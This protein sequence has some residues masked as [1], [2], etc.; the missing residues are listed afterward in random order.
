MKKRELSKKKVM[1]PTWPGIDLIT[2][3][4]VIDPF[5]AVNLFKYSSTVNAPAGLGLIL[6]N[7]IRTAQIGSCIGVFVGLTQSIKIHNVGVYASR[8]GCIGGILGIS[9]IFGKTIIDQSMS[10][11]GIDEKTSQLKENVD[12]E[13]MT[14]TTLTFS[15]Y[16]NDV[17]G[18]LI[19][20]YINYSNIF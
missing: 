11:L 3:N 15:M 5:R 19:F 18:S 20:F 13:T 17:V 12:D 8:G 7:S 16:V 4:G 10:P 6:H 9:L 1:P 2:P 14:L